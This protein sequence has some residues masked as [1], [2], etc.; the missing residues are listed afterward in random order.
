[1][2]FIPITALL[3][4]TLASAAHA[5]TLEGQVA[6]WP[7]GTAELFGDATGKVPPVIGTITAEGA[8]SLALPADTASPLTLGNLPCV[9]D[10]GMT[11]ENLEAS[12]FALSP[13]LGVKSPGEFSPDKVL[14]RVVLAESA[15][16]ARWL[17]DPMSSPAVTGRY[18]MLIHVGETASVQGSCT[19]DMSFLQK[20]SQVIE[21]D[22][23]LNAGWNLIVSEITGVS[24]DAVPSVTSQ[25]QVA[26][27]LD[28]L[29][30]SW[31]LVTP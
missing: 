18:A 19:M 5:E 15:E 1:M 17:T 26:A 14:G 29:D 10:P 21:L 30:L 6:D 28:E 23:R 16:V 2:K 11:G 7:G 3:A 20:P 25:T 12:V 27:P 8:V 22:Y 31:R 13:V 4:A 24:P 9:N